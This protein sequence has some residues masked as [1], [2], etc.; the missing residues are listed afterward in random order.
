ML[1]LLDKILSFGGL[2]K[3]GKTISGAVLLLYYVISTYKPEYV[4]LIVQIAQVLGV[5]LLPIGV[6]HKV[7][8]SEMRSN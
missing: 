8:K 5:S 3:G 6:A 4:P 2:F 1:S 7:V